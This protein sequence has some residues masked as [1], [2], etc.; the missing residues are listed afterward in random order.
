MS[1]RMGVDV[2]GTFTDIVCFD[3]ERGR[4]D[5]LK[6]P[7]TPAE[8]HR[9]V[10]EGAARILEE[11]GL[12][13][14]SV[15]FFIHGTTVATNT[16]LERK[17]ARV[18]LLV[19]EGF[20]DVLY[21][22]RQDRPRLYDYF[23]QR[24]DPLV[25]R[26]LRR[27]IAERTLHTGGVHRPLD[28]GAARAT[29]RELRAAGLSDIAICLLHSYANPQHER[30][31]RAL[32][33]EEL[34]GA[35]VS[36]SSEVLPEFKEFERMNTTV[37]DAYV[38][39]K[40]AAYVRNLRA[41]LASLG[42]PSGLHIMQSN[43]GIMTAETAESHSVRTVLSGPA[44]GAVAGLVIARQA[45]VEN[46]I[47]IDVGGTSADVA[48]AYGGHL[49]YAEE[50]E[51]GG[52]VIKTPAID[53]HTVGAGGGS[54]AWIDPGGA[55]QVGPQS[56]GADPGPACYGR[57]G[58]EPTVTDA[59]LALGR[60]NADYF[61]GGAM[62]IDDT[63]ARRAIEERIAR[64]LGLGVAAAAEGILRVINAVMAKAIRRLSV[65]KGYDPREFTLVAFGGAGPLH[66]TTLASELQVPRVLVPPAPGVSSA[67]GLLTADFR[68]DYVRTVLGPVSGT[69]LEA[70]RRLY[71]EL[72]E[73]ATADMRRERVAPERVSLLASVDMRYQGQG[74]SLQ[75]RFTLDELDAW[76]DLE[77]LVARFHELHHSA[78]G[79]SDAREATEI[80]NVRLAAIGRLPE[81]RLQ[82]LAQGSEDPSAAFKRRRRVWID[83][84]PQDAAVYDRTRLLAGNRVEGPAVIEQIDSTTVIFRGQRAVV[85]EFGNVIVLLEEAR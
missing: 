53:I 45:G 3:E 82:P 58:A 21:I 78:Y 5:L 56:A 68:H 67:L 2:G 43:G 40:V 79:Y 30:A 71:T 18:A 48:V 75:P 10:V 23:V 54:I 29:L 36:I 72:R 50:T 62:S 47:S 60:L 16:I 15:D 38:R 84:A 66:A 51:I 28:E 69:S 73:R 80:V 26:H 77:P 39:P 34:P 27:E 35:R 44:A 64:P 25:P 19:T 41:G 32:V 7:S 74:F 52:Q 37:V 63:L 57:G 61:L 13:S 46:M 70:L 8:P 76:T 65:E 24:P 17:G 4:L 83:G 31:L 49:H 59:N 42:V 22:M 55:L 12:D 33:L 6:V 81:P 85:D 1:V 9:A 11:A 20:R 14:A